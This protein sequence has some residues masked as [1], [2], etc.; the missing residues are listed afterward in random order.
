[1]AK[2]LI[3]SIGTGALNTNNQAVR[4]YRTAKYRIDEQEYNKSFISS[5]LYEHL[6]LD[7]IIFI[8]TVKSM[9]EEVYRVFCEEKNINFD[10]EYYFKLIETIESL[11]YQSD[12]D[13]LN[14]QPIKQ[15]LGENSQ[16]I[17][18]KYG[19]NEAELQENFDQ[20]IKIV[21]FLQNGDELY[22]D[23]T[24]SFR[25][26]SLFMFLVLNFV[27]DLYTERNIKVK[28]VY[29]GMLDVTREFGYAPV[30]DL[31]SLFEVTEWIKGLYS[32]KSFG[33]GY[34]ISELLQ[35]QGQKDLARKIRELSDAININYLPDISQRSKLLN[36]SLQTTNLT[37]P[38]QYLKKIL[39]K[40]IN[41]FSQKNERESDFQ[42]KLSK[43][44]FDNKRYA[45]GYITL[46]EAIITYMCELEGEDIVSQ[47]ARER[48][49]KLLRKNRHTEIAQLYFKVNKIRNGIAHALIEGER[50]SYHTAISN[51]E[52][53][54][55]KAKTIFDSN[56]LI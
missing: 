56:A 14:L 3:S 47:E 36:T 41:R 27:N 30:V 25:S 7:S 22:I 11:N 1:M 55:Q 34:L 49:K 4:E 44:Y 26:L 39:E 6:K 9:W 46:A 29:Y 18:I 21:D 53:Y 52:G 38:F 8:G 23:L 40:F 37:S 54:Y 50:Q 16:C 31:Q 12:L 10:E 33:N 2:I 5:V 17:L 42:L 32:L 28:G 43:W 13:S 35:N 24:H 15:V 51:A 48:M 19:L 45:T 20:I